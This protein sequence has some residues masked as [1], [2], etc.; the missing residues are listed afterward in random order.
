[1]GEFLAKEMGRSEFVLG[2][3]LY[4][5]RDGCWTR[6]EHFCGSTSYSARDKA[7]DLT[8]ATED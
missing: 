3:F 2:D 1:M 8:L 6:Q 5:G 7:S 4:Q